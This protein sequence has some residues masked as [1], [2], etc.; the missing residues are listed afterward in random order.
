[1]WAGQHEHADPQ[2]GT[3]YKL[4]EG[5]EFAR[6]SASKLRA[7]P[8]AFPVQANVNEDENSRFLNSESGSLR[9]GFGSQV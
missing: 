9:A 7:N 1:M 3:N 2:C 5:S 8:E 6:K 4:S